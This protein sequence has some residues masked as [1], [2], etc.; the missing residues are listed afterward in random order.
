MIRIAALIP[1]HDRPDFLSQRALASIVRQTRIPDYLVIVGD[2][3]PTH[4]A[5][6]R[7]VADRF[8]FPATQVVYLENSRTPGLTGAVNTALTWMQAETPGAFVALLDDDDWASTHL[9]RCEDAIG[10]NSWMWWRPASSIM[11]L[12]TNYV[13]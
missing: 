12:T 2:S 1:T 8:K 10:E 11:D 13:I 4:R 5:A 3:G 9:E 7:R 6:N